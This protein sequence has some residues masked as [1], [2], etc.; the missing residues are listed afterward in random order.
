MYGIRW[1]LLFQD[2]Q[3]SRGLQMSD[4]PPGGNEGEMWGIRRGTV[5]AKCMG[6]PRESDMVETMQDKPQTRACF[7]LL[8][9]IVRLPAW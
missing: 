9:S 8:E 5:E 7:H 3:V 1:A 4:P 6:L 2:A